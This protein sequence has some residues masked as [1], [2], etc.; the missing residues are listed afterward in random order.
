MVLFYM[1]KCQGPRW[2]G[3]LNNRVML[4]IVFQLLEEYLH[5]P[6]HSRPRFIFDILM[7][8][9][10]HIIITKNPK[11]LMHQSSNKR[12]TNS[13][14]SPEIERDE[15][16]MIAIPIKTQTHA[17]HFKFSRRKGN[18]YS[19][20]ERVWEI[21]IE[22][23]GRIFSQGIVGI[24]RRRAGAGQVTETG[25]RATRRRRMA[26][27]EAEVGRRKPRVR[28]RRTEEELRLMEACGGGGG[29]KRPNK[30]RER[31]HVVHSRL[32]IDL[33]LSERTETTKTISGLLYIILIGSVG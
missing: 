8:K 22:T 6:P 29:K 2:H 11:K 30:R 33:W 23:C 13:S 32:W 17:Q 7:S 10:L 31:R 27:M 9:T 16:T 21:E 20:R 5:A 12:S 3:S 1:V 18:R 14:K 24:G 15:F 4:P 26:E 25:P 28:S 19:G